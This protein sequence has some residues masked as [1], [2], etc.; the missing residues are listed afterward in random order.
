MLAVAL[1]GAACRGPTHGPREVRTVE[2]WEVQVVP[3]A[4]EP[5]PR[6]PPLREEGWQPVAALSDRRLEE[7]GGLWARAPL[8]QAP[9]APAVLVVRAYVRELAVYVDGA[10][11]YR[12]SAEARPAAGASLA[13]HVIRLPPAPPGSRGSTLHVWW[14]DPDPYRFAVG[15]W[16]LVAEADLPVALRE[17]VATPLRS[18][19]DDLAIGW[20]TL[21]AGVVAGLGAAARRDRLLAFFAAFSAL[22]GLRLLVVAHP[23]FLFGATPL[24]AYGTASAI[25]YLINVPAAGFWVELLGP[26]WRYSRLL[27]GGVAAF[28]A[29]GIAADHVTGTPFAAAT[30]NNVVVLLAFTALTVALLRRGR[31]WS[32]GSRERRVLIGGTAVFLLFAAN[33]NLVGLG[34][35][36]WHW[37]YEPLGF[38]VFLGALGWVA[39]RRFLDN[40]RRLLALDGE[41]EAARRIQESILPAVTPQ[42]RGLA[43]AARYAPMSA[44]GGDLYDFAEDPQGGLGV[45]VADVSG[46]GVPAALIASMVK[47]TYTA[48]QR[49][50]DEPAALLTEMNRMLC[51][52][53]LRGF[54]TATCVWA[55]AGGRTLTVA[56]AGHPPPLLRSREGGVEALLPEGPLLGR[57]AGAAFQ[58]VE[59]PFRPGDRLLLYT[60]GLVEAR[61]SEEPFGE[62][63]LRDLLE[64]GTTTGAGAFADHLL[65]TVRTWT[66]PTPP[67]DDLTLVVLDGVPPG[68]NGGTAIS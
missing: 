30:A 57:F 4:E 38:L 1:A 11:V 10:R 43:V 27:L 22:Y 9:A 67:D 61:R 32:G 29:V 13:Y 64:Q 60:D 15:P 25:T 33:E 19:L 37:S 53:S 49:H 50:A 23:A 2:G 28:A 5:G 16:I 12:W 48:L 40:E 35:L 21:L 68:A 55:E 66:A 20:L 24:L 65:E 42:P 7:A 47:M 3:A 34:W 39:G 45:L 46:H 59:V 51:G 44:V 52:R 31:P 54:V 36:P 56:R 26:R 41:L 17:Y 18:D 6:L 8:P 14:P 62:P 58:E 63:R